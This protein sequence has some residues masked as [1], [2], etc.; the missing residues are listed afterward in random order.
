MI[1][2]GSGRT[3]YQRHFDPV[4]DQAVRSKRPPRLIANVDLC[5]FDLAAGLKG[6]APAVR[7]F[8]GSELDLPQFGACGVEL[9][10]PAELPGS[11][12]A[13][14]CLRMARTF[15]HDRL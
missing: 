7:L 9:S 10:V 3:M 1:G 2:D 14:H 13:S 15:L 8:V 4:L 6:I 5:E 11:R 12:R